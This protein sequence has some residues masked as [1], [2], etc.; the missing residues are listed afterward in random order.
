MSPDPGVFS[1]GRHD[2]DGRAVFVPRGE[3]DLATAG[4]LEQPLL[5]ALDEGRSVVIDLRELAFMD[6]SGIRVIIAAHGH[7]GDRGERLALIRPPDGGIVA[8][9]LEIA[10]VGEV[11]RMVDGL[12]PPDR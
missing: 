6:S 9:I 11:L 12:E 4:E 7:A 5:A 1:V 3:L 10:G 2:Q 8:R